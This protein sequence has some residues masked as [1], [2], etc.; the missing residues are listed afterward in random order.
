MPNIILGLFGIAALIWRARFAERQ[1]AVRACRSACRGCRHGG[2]GPRRRRRPPEARERPAP[3][4]AGR[5]VVIVIRVPHLR[6]PAPGL[7]DRYISRHLPAD[8]RRSSFV[9][10]LGLFYISTF[11]DKSDKMFKGQATTGTVLQLLVYMTP[12]FVYYVIPIAALLE[13]AGDLR[14]AVA[15]RAS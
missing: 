8:R 13:R 10:L 1:P 9:A 3:R 11:I 4:V 6:L 14:A 12:Q 2:R 7:L 15:Q 5:K